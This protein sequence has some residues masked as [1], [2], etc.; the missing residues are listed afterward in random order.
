MM[1]DEDTG[2]EDDEAQEEN[3]P[4]GANRGGRGQT[5]D[6]DNGAQNRQPGGAGVIPQAT[7]HQKA[8]NENAYQI[9]NNGG[10]DGK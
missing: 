3:D 10:F 1:D 7:Q 5:S 8:V 2:Q 4:L 9:P 6:A